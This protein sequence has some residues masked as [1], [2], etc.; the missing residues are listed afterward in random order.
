MIVRAAKMP[1]ATHL[2]RGRP[3]AIAARNPEIQR[4][5][6]EKCIKNPTATKSVTRPIGILDLMPLNW[7]Y[8]E[9]MDLTI[10][11]HQYW[12]RTASN[13]NS[14]F[15]IG[16]DLKIRFLVCSFSY[17]TLSI[18]AIFK[19]IFAKSFVSSNLLDCA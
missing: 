10:L 7:F 3:T 18:S 8:R 17:S 9:L 2:A 16:I 6:G 19:A 15:S 14:A 11:C 12:L 1:A 4:R 5:F 13:H